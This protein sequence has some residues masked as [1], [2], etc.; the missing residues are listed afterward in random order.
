MR[1]IFTGLRVGQKLLN[2]EILKHVNSIFFTPTHH[3]LGGWHVL[4]ISLKRL[5][6]FTIH[7]FEELSI[8]IT[9]VQA[10]L[11]SYPLNSFVQ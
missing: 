3:T 11:N 6:R 10:C 9:Q 2:L 8:P 4:K 7:T 5:V 1:H